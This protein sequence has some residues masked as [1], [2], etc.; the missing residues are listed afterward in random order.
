MCF[1][2]VRCAF[3]DYHVAIFDEVARGNTRA[4]I[5]FRFVYYC[6]LDNIKP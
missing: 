5:K 6:I 3:A 1:Q 2:A 4:E